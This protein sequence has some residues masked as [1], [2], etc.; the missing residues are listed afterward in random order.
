MNDTS[1]QII[2]ESL[3][4]TIETLKIRV[5]FLEKKLLSSCKRPDGHER[6]PSCDCLSQETHDSGACQ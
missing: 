6:H 3:V 2:V 1:Y 4:L 5:N